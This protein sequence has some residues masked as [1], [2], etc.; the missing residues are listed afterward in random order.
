MIAD[1][2]RN[3]DWLKISLFIFSLTA[4]LF[5]T[6]SAASCFAGGIVFRATLGLSSDQTAMVLSLGSLSV[7]LS[8]IHFSAL[9]HAFK[10]SPPAPMPTRSDK[11]LSISSAAMLC[12]ILVMGISYFNGND[13]L[14]T[15]IQPYLTPLAIWIPIWWF[16]E[17]GKRKLPSI[18]ARKR[19]AALS[20]G[21]SYVIVFIMAL[22]LIVFALLI[23]GLLIYLNTQPSIQQ[24]IRTL[25]IPEDLSQI[26]T[27]FIEQYIHRILQNPW[28][29]AIVFMVI[30]VI[31]PF[32]EESLKPAALWVLQKRSLTPSQ[33][34]IL[35]LYFGGAFALI[36]NAGM[37]IQLGSQSWSE[38]VLLRAATALLHITCSGLVG[39][40]YARSMQ[41]GKTSA[42]LKP[43]LLALLLHGAWNSMAVL[44]GYAFF[45]SETGIDALSSTPALKLISIIA[46]VLIWLII[47][48]LLWKKNQDLRKETSFEAHTNSAGGVSM[49]KVE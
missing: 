8:V 5:T 12:W 13:K 46:L 7:L 24:W 9:R 25:S 22:E 39:C 28:F 37:V 45:S 43:F 47:V 30:G 49:N 33:G 29:L 1:E 42:F 4:W 26:D 17:F 15:A 27:R 34:F 40:G 19:N 36:E 6:V 35:G 18:T 21:S 38:S 48:Y 23:A 3:R 31:A 44:S 2:R 11:A 16:I 20:I 32:I 14:F 41:P 10:N